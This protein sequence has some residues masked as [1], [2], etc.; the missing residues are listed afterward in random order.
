MKTKTIPEKTQLQI[1][2]NLFNEGR[3]TSDSL[4]SFFTKMFSIIYDLTGIETGGVYLYDETLERAGLEYSENIP[5]SLLSQ[6]DQIQR[7]STLF[8]AVFLNGE[9]HGETENIPGIS[10]ENRSRLVY[11]PIFFG[12]RVNGCIMAASENPDKQDY[13]EDAILAFIG[14]NSGIIIEKIKTEEFI[15]KSRDVYDSLY[16]QLQTSIEKYEETNERLNIM[17]EILIQSQDEL[18][19][20]NSKLKKSEERYRQLYEGSRDGWAMIDLDGNFVEF[21]SIFCSM[22]GYSSKEMLTMTN[23]EI[24]VPRWRKWEETEVLEK[25]LKKRGYSDLYEKEHLRKDGTTFPVEIRAYAVKEEGKDVGY[26]AF[27]RDI[28]DRKRIEKELKEAKARAEDSELIKSAFI[29]NV[30]HEIRT[31]MNAIIGYTDLIMQDDL[32]EQH[33][34]YLQIIKNSGKLLLSIINDILDLSKI[35]AGQIDVERIPFSLESVLESVGHN[36]RILLAQKESG[37][38]LSSNIP[39]NVSNYIT[40]DPTTILQVMNNLMS[41]AVKFT[42]EGTIEYGV[43]L[44]DPKTIQFYVK[45]T[46]IGIRDDSVGRI[47]NRFQQADITTKRKYGGTGLG[48]NISKK[49]VELI[50][51]NLDVIS[52]VGGGK[53]SLFYFNIPYVPARRK[54]PAETGKRVKEIPDRPCTILVAEDNHVNQTLTKRVLE[55][56]GYTVITADDGKEALNRYKTVPDIDLILMDIQMPVVDGLEAITVI[57]DIENSENREKTPVIALT[58]HAMKSDMSECIAAGCDDFI[59]KPVNR[60]SLIETIENYLFKNS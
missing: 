23:I 57:R 31:P 14:R 25:Q 1:L 12:D 27:V 6:Y 2:L 5:G 48:L 24:T 54:K 49:L 58:A 16:K 47:F 39:E 30:S 46:G 42:P 56:A 41:N 3:L 43:R 37:V 10:G 20:I 13:E 21:N 15:N 18:I 28:T 4:H 8:Q 19:D 36:G 45:D 35:E 40:S 32:P 11:V 60:D 51:G 53:G 38:T 29:A 52:P 22:H 33:R 34:E 7:H 9:I 44:V 17:N 26:W 55:K 50:G 59:T